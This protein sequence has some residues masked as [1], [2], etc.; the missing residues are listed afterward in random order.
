[1]SHH[2]LTGYRV[3]A[4]PKIMHSYQLGKEKRLHRLC[5]G[6]YLCHHKPNQAISHL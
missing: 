3:K 1:M 5:N 2:L 4:A 6:Q